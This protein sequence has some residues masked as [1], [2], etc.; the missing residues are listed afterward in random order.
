VA[1]I[2]EP[3]LKCDTSDRIVA[4]CEA[5]GRP[6]DTQPADVP[7]RRHAGSASE[8]ACEVAWVYTALRRELVDREGFA[9]TVMD[10]LE[11]DRQRIEDLGAAL[12]RTV[13]VDLLTA[14]RILVA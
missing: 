1:L 9:K 10:Q 14:I 12:V 11:S 6:F 4:V 5:S 3:G 7:P 2:R 8:H 13:H